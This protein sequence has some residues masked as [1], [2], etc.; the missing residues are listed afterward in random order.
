VCLKNSRGVGGRIS[1]LVDH[2]HEYPRVLT[3]LC[4]V[5]RIWPIGAA[6][7]QRSSSSGYIDSSHQDRPHSDRFHLSHTDRHADRSLRRLADDAHCDGRGGTGLA[8]PEY[9]PH[10]EQPC[11]RRSLHGALWIVVRRRRSLS[12]FVD[13]TAYD[14]RSAGFFR[15]R[16]RRHGADYLWTSPADCRLRMAR[17]LSRVRHHSAGR[18]GCVRDCRTQCSRP[19]SSARDPSTSRAASQSADLA[20]RFLLC[21]HLRSLRRAYADAWRHLCRCLQDFPG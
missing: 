5:G 9:R 20:L 15:S 12:F 19:R 13:S 18:G 10:P 2:C 16:Q 3:L 6:H 14:R 21:G 11:D 4:R 8:L 1:A 17:L 7:R